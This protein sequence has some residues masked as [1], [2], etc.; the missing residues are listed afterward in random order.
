MK[1]NFIANKAF[2]LAEVLVTLAVIGVVAAL[3]IPS[4]IKNYQDSVNKIRWKKEYSTLAQAVRATAAD[5]DGNLVGY[6]AGDTDL[7]TKI[8][9]KL[10]TVKQ[11]SAAHPEECWHEE[12]ITK[13]LNGTL[14]DEY[15]CSSCG[16]ITSILPDGGYLKTDLDDTTCTTSW[17]YGIPIC[18][19]VVV[20]VNGSGGPNIY[21]KDIFGALITSTGLKPMG[22]Q[23]SSINFAESTS[24]IEGS[25]SVNNMGWGCS[26][27]YLKE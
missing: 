14:H 27:K 13:Y 6:F 21:G 10:K 1:T 5:N 12:G 19:I 15:M 18:G 8:R 4:L 24:C 23:G 22:V 20:D 17:Q 3:T 16:Q 2:T 11:C 26:G 7:A 25:T 9:S